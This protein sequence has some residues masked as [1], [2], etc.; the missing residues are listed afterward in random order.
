[1]SSREG[2]STRRAQLTS[3]ASA[4][5]DLNSLGGKQYSGDASR[6]SQAGDTSIGQNGGSEADDES[7][8]T[9]KP[10]LKKKPTKS[11]KAADDSLTMSKK[12]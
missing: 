11:S 7:A 8:M 6:W 4:T 1:M 5:K 9:E 10:K 12:L 2:T 3:H